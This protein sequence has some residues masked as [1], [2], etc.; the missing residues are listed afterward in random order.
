MF[1]FLIM[2]CV[3]VAYV[4][5]LHLMVAISSVPVM[6]TNNLTVK[7]KFQVCFRTMH[8]LFIVSYMHCDTD[9]GSEF[10]V[11]YHRLCADPVPHESRHTTLNTL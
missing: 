6:M 1:C 9:C 5:S 8:N 2:L 3:A 11:V 10:V 7:Q 4:A